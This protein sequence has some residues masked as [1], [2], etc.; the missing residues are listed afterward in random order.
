V[1]DDSTP[2][3]LSERALHLARALYVPA[4]VGVVLCPPCP[5]EGSGKKRIVATRKRL[6]EAVF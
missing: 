4:G 1:Q 2:T 3:P 5:L 6:G